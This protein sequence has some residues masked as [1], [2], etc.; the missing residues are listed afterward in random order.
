MKRW[1]LA[2]GIAVLVGAA[3][4]L[5]VTG[6]TE[7]RYSA[8]HDR[9]EPMWWRWLP[10]AVGILLIRLVP[11]RLDR[12]PEGRP[13]VRQAGILAGL[14]VAFA[15]LL[16]LTG[17]FEILKGVLLLAVPICMF[18]WLG[19]R[20]TA[21]RP[22][23]PVRWEPAVPVVAW[24]LLTYVGPLQPQPSL[25][26]L[27]GVQL[28]LVVVSVFLVNSVLEEFFY[29]RWLQTRWEQLLGP[30]LA[31]VLA[32]ILWAVWHVGIQG[33]G[34][35]GLDLAGA[36]VNQGVLGLFLG[37]LWSRYRLMWP[38]IVVHGATNSMGILLALV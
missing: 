11:V 12:G 6:N 19:E 33:S 18:R 14:A 27:T 31:I 4:A 24:L 29:R 34:P 20:P 3:V 22:A 38:L 26:Y 35:L 17:Q 8:D 2:A 36:L 30:W 37:Y 25:S 32:S 16:K 15:V 23:P 13:D 1:V 5:V 28:A 10:A 21:G 9:T 7:I